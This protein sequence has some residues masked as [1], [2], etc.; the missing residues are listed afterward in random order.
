MAATVN[1]NAIAISPGRRMISIFVYS[2]RLNCSRF[3]FY[4]SRQAQIIEGVPRPMRRLLNNVTAVTR[5]ATKE[6]IMEKAQRPGDC[7]SPACAS[8]K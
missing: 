3:D 8:H 6:K 1:D 7:S 4:T 2:L 5:F